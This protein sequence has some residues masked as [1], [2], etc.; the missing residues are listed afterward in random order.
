MLIM[1]LG[2]V[3]EHATTRAQFGQYLSEFPLIKVSLYRKVATIS[4]IIPFKE[5]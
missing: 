2:L 3:A 4:L 5:S 1:I